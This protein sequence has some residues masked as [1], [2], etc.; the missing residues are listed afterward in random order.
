M[1]RTMGSEYRYRVMRIDV[2]F[3][4]SQYAFYWLSSV[5]HEEMIYYNNS[6]KGV[7]TV[8]KAMVYTS[9]ERPGQGVRLIYGCVLNTRNYGTRHYNLG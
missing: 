7:R 3:H 9:F 4:S 6:E 5:I 1:P 8:H 2:T